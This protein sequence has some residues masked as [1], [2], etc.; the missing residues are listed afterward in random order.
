M[1]KKELF[2]N[3]SG[4]KTY[5]NGRWWTDNGHKIALEIENQIKHVIEKYAR[6]GYNVRELKYIADSVT[7]N[8]IYDL[9][10]Q[11]RGKLND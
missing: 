4:N 2:T 1:E 10:L 11:D 5:L 7:D 9:C 3:K 8:I 6:E